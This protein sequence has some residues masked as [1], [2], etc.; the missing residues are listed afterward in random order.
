[1]ISAG[2]PRQRNATAV[3]E[4]IVEGSRCEESLELGETEQQEPVRIVDR[5]REA[6]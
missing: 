5:A 1:M 2:P 4:G 3:P 6:F